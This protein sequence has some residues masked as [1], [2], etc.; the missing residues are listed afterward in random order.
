MNACLVRDNTASGVRAEH[1]SLMAEACVAERNGEAGFSCVGKGSELFIRDCESSH[2]TYGYNCRQPDSCLITH[3]QCTFCE[4]GITV[5]HSSRP[6]LVRNCN[7]AKMSCL[8]IYTE[9]SDRV[10]VKQCTVT[11]CQERGKNCPPP[12]GLTVKN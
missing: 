8:G 7:M 10:D 12:Q 3:S 5:Y 2:S 1:S 11:E 6:A 9:E 4:F